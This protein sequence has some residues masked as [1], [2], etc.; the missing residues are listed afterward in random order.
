MYRKFW[1]VDD[2]SIFLFVSFLPFPRYLV[3]I[4][5]R[6]LVVHGHKTLTMSQAQS[7]CS[8]TVQCWQHLS[9]QK[10]PSLVHYMIFLCHEVGLVDG[11]LAQYT[12]PALTSLNSYINIPYNEWVLA[13]H[14]PFVYGFW[15]FPRSRISW[16]K[17]MSRSKVHIVSY[18]SSPLQLNIVNILAHI[19]T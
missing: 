8:I 15:L 10:L 9:G 3:F 2:L 12:H 16:K 7:L 17:C 13:C 14:L 11:C 4:K 6:V 5:A 19:L 1:I 18:I